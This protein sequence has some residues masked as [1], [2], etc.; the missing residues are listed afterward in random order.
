MRANRC[1]PPRFLYRTSSLRAVQVTTTHEH[2]EIAR[3]V[4]KAVVDAL[5]A[6]SLAAC[7]IATNITLGTEVTTSQ[8]AYRL[9][10]REHADDAAR[11]LALVVVLGGVETP[12]KLSGLLAARY[13][14]TR[15]APYAPFPFVPT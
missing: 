4:A 5:P 15:R 3:A 13:G 12:A 8:G 14:L 2:A 10:A 9:I 6:T 1:G 7:G 11:P